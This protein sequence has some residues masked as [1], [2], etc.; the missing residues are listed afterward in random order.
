[1]SN[2]IRHFVA[3]D[4]DFVILETYVNDQPMVWV[5]FSYEQ[6]GELIKGIQKTKRQLKKRMDAKPKH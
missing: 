4:R 3:E 2:G 5:D 6:L 1:M